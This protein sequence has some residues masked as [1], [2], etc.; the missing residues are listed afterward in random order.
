MSGRLPIDE[1]MR[2]EALTQKRKDVDM[3][4]FCNKICG[5]C[6]RCKAAMEDCCREE[7]AYAECVQSEYPR[8]RLATFGE[9]NDAMNKRQRISF[10]KNE[11]KRLERELCHAKIKNHPN[12]LGTARIEIKYYDAKRE[13]KELT[14]EKT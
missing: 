11:I 1:T 7:L 2:R 6:P 10:L 8:I 13:L 14:D 12:D 4:E 5:N 9:E 3:T